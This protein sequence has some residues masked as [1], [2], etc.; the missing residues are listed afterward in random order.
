M[1][2]TQPAFL[3][4]L[5]TTFVLLSG[6]HLLQ[7]QKNKIQEEKKPWWDDPQPR[8]SRSELGDVFTGTIDMRGDAKVRDR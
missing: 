7:A 6:S 4:S 2:I 1:I 8:F 5:V 3:F